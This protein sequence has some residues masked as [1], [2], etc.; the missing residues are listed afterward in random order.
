MKIRVA[1]A[2]KKFVIVS[3]TS[4]EI[5]K[6]CVEEVYEIIKNS[7]NLL[8]KLYV[9]LE[10]HFTN[11]SVY[12][13][14]LEKISLEETDLIDRAFVDSIAFYHL[15]GVSLLETFRPKFE[16]RKFDQ[17]ERFV[18]LMT[19]ELPPSWSLVFPPLS[20]DGGRRIS[21]ILLEFV[22]STSSGL[23]LE[24]L[25]DAVEK[26]V[27]AKREWYSQETSL[28]FP[29]DFV[30]GKVK[31]NRQIVRKIPQLVDI[32][33]ML[34][35]ALSVAQDYSTLSMNSDTGILIGEMFPNI[36]KGFSRIEEFM[37][38]IYLPYRESVI[39][40]IQ[41]D[42]VQQDVVYAV[43]FW[44]ECVKGMGVE[45]P[46]D[47]TDGLEEAYNTLSSNPTYRSFSILQQRLYHLDWKLTRYVEK[48][49]L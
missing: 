39:W 1:H 19:P 46:S 20:D 36:L 3:T 45:I 47:I 34:I 42:V 9:W 28:V 17:I 38:N 32:L 10:D 2:L 27:D 16:V 18:K 12:P 5:K 4:D 8:G 30:L 41:N 49:G 35:G 33:I 13:A 6:T 26:Y 21:Y 40:E 48:L 37:T 23:E 11:L 7:E 24:K 29:L 15:F 22:V 31:A 43:F 44:A 14:D 25:N